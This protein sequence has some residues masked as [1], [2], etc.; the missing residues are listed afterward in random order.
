[1][2]DVPHGSEVVTWEYPELLCPL[3]IQQCNHEVSPQEIRHR[4][5]GEPHLESL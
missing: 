1:M 3:N 4:W 2:F 5:V